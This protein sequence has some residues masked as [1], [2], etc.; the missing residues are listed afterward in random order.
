MNLE[1]KLAANMMSGLVVVRYNKFPTRLDIM[2]VA[3][4][5]SR[6]MHYLVIYILEQQKES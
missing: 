1:R 3:S 4:L 2:F 6:F 5:L